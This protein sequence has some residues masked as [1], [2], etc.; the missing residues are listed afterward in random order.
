MI[1]YSMKLLIVSF[2]IFVM[3][4]TENSNRNVLP[5]SDRKLTYL[6]STFNKDFEYITK[7]D[8]ASLIIPLFKDSISSSY[9]QIPD[10]DPIG[11]YYR[12]DLTGNTIACIIDLIAESNWNAHLLIEIMHTKRKIRS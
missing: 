3:S 6:K 5:E 8:A 7:K 11:K 10:N 12:S 9:D 2:L 1:L 4:C